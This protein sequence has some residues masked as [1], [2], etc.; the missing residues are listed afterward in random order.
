M[1]S[2]MDPQGAVHRAA[3]RSRPF[4]WTDTLAVTAS[5]TFLGMKTLIRILEMTMDAWSSG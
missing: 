2:R 1:G 4:L 3:Q 5:W